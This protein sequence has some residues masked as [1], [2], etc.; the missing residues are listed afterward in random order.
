M[1]QIMITSMGEFMLS[2]LKPKKQSLGFMKICDNDITTCGG[3]ILEM[4]SNH[5]VYKKYGWGWIVAIGHC[6]QGFLMW[7]SEAKIK[8]TTSIWVSPEMESNKLHD[9]V[10][11]WSMCSISLYWWSLRQF[12]AHSTLF[13]DV[14]ISRWGIY[15]NF[16][17]LSFYLSFAYFVKCFS[18]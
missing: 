9:L 10:M 5:E 16:S 4:V 15:T 18:L 6:T 8:L 7:W 17:L 1:W 2:I 13:S 14:L 3:M 11:A 12:S